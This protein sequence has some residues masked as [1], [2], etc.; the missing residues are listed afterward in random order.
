MTSKNVAH[1]Q[2]PFAFFWLP[3][4]VLT[5]AVDGYFDAFFAVLAPKGRQQ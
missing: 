2:R 3:L 5:A 1:N 4:A